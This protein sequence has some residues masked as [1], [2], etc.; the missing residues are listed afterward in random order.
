MKQYRIMWFAAILAVFGLVAAACGGDDDSDVV[1]ADAD[2]AAAAAADAAALEQAQEDAAAARAEAGEAAAEAEKA[3]AALDAA[4]A[5][6]EAAEGNV[7]PEVVA[8]LEQQLKD[9][10]D[11]AAAAQAEADKAAAAAEEAAARA[12]AAEAEAEMAAQEMEEE[13]PMEE[14]DPMDYNGDG[15]VRVAVA[16]AGD[17]NDG[18]YY[19]A[20]VDGARDFTSANGYADPI[21]IDKIDQAEA[22]TELRNLA[23]QGVDVIVVS[24]GEISEPLED[25]T[26]EYPDIFW[27]CRCEDTFPDLPG[28]AQSSDNSAAIEYIAGFAAGLLL[29]ERGGDSVYMLGGSSASFEVETELA[30]RLGLQSVDAGYEINYVPTG[31]QPFDFDNVAGASEAFHNAVA[32]GADAVYPYLGGAHNPV[33]ALA[34]EAGLITMSA[35][36]SDVCTREGDLHWDIAIKFDGG[37]YIRAVFPLI[38]QGRLAEGERFVFS[39]EPGSVAG[40]AICDPTPEQAEALEAEVVKVATGV[41][42][43]QFNEI[44]AIAYG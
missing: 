32:A 30:F 35:G 31:A 9:A 25:L 19:Q 2:A 20:A 44:R 15:V 34:N 36:A 8:E 11:A 7:D 3:A 29:Q 33:V 40:A 43:D 18:A 4:M 6:A 22:A 23:D 38:Q 37:D 5:A 41:Y 1:T 10:Q 17:A 13:A 39:V 16:V 26:E 27:Y 24:S 12:E 28:L 21:Y 14:V 42:E